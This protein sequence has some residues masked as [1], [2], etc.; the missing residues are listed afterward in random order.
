MPG[1][2]GNKHALGCKTSGRP[3]KYTDEVKKQEFQDLLEWSKNPDSFNLLDFTFNKDYTLSLLG[4]WSKEN[5]E[6][7]AT[8]KKAKERLGH[9]IRKKLHDKISPY[10][11]GAFQREIGMYDSNLNEYERAEKI[12][13]AN[14]KKLNQDSEKENLAT[15]VKKLAD[16]LLSQK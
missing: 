3:K 6:F 4:E 8:Y 16:G 1:P 7:S 14:L 2:I 5:D 15:F 13:E 10:N 9:N 11:Y 12:F